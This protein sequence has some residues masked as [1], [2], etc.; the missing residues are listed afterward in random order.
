MVPRRDAQKVM[1]D[2]F[3]LGAKGILTTDIHASRI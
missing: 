3:D 2:L 1:D